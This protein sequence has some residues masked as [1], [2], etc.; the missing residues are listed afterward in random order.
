MFM[1]VDMWVV[2]LVLMVIF[3][4][5]EAA[6]LGITT[7]WC[8]AGCLVAAIMDLLGAPVG[9]Q[10]IAM[11]AVSVVCFIACLIW[12]RPMFD[13]KHKRELSPTN[14][15]RVLGHEGIVI[16]TIDPMDGKGQIKVLGQ[17]WSAKADKVIEEGS[18][19]K[20]LSMEGVKLIVEE[21]K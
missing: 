7:V 2:W 1:N 19:V 20:V 11:I 15:D 16:K 12:I 17:V 14:A 21:L 13:A 10:V 4:I 5:I 18:K 8:A 9:A 3:L 6:T